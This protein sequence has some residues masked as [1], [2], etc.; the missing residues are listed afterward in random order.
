[1]DGVVQGT[2]RLDGD[3][4]ANAPAGNLHIGREDV[5]PAPAVAVDEVELWAVARHRNEVQK[6]AYSTPP[7]PTTRAQPNLPVAPGLD[8]DFLQIPTG[9][10]FD[11]TAD[12]VALG[13]RLFEDPSLSGDGT[14]ACA[15]CHASDHF[16]MQGKLSGVGPGFSLGFYGQILDRQTPTIANRGF[17]E[18]QFWDGRS[19]SLEDQALQPIF[20]PAE[21]DGDPND[22]AALLASDIYA[23]DFQIAYGVSAPTLEHLS[24]ALAAYMR[25]VQL[26]DSAADRFEAGTQTLSAAA[27]AGRE[28]FFGKGRCST[29]HTGPN[30]SDEQ[31]HM[32]VAENP[33][34]GAY[35]VTGRLQDFAAF[36]TPT[37][38]TG[39]ATG[40]FF[41]NG[42]AADLTEVVARYNAGIPHANP[43]PGARDRDPQIRP[44]GLGRGE[45]AA[46]V[47]F[48][49]ALE[50]EAY[51][52][53]P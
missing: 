3:H 29:C 40:A 33:D 51:E 52:V 2:D 16:F 12:R 35:Q 45:A 38:R 28:I 24:L 41:H 21:M 14:M 4:P 7:V 46:L 48:L 53:F 1:V 25:N 36:K 37:L 22:V 31:L 9:H 27:T 39:G 50:S 30:F 15:T 17:G 20:D 44:L 23:W 18:R 13:R 5:A 49:E 6:M 11:V 32:T 26:G 47:A 19:S 43:I 10:E 8:A 42:S 34:A